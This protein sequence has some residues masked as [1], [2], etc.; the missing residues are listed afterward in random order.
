MTDAPK[1]W[2]PKSDS[3]TPQP[4][5]SAGKGTRSGAI[6]RKQYVHLEDELWTPITDEVIALM[7]EARVN[8]GGNWDL[9]GRTIG[10]RA[11]ILRRYRTKDPDTKPT[12]RRNAIPFGILDKVLTVGGIGNRIS[13][14][15]WYTTDQM[16]EKGHWRPMLDLG[17][18]AR[19]RSERSS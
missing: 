7:E 5:G 18:V 17:D 12:R 1:R 10:H 11:R 15:P 2:L 4:S 3:P 14:L 19:R 9:L 8:F 6:A 16:V 13:E